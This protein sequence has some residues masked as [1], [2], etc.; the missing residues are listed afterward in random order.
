M[1]D[2]VKVGWLYDKWADE[3]YDKWIYKS[4]WDSKIRDPKTKLP[5]NTTMS[6][7]SVKKQYKIIQ[8]T[9]IDSDT[10]KLPTVYAQKMLK[11]AD[12]EMLKDVVAK[13]HGVDKDELFVCDI[14]KSKIHR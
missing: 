3:E 11:V 10:S 13:K 2:A 4:E 9:W 6:S 12:I 7:N 8:Y 1:P 14:W 5:Y